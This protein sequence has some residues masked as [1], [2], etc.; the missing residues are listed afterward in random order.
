MIQDFMLYRYP[1][2]GL[3]LNIWATALS[4][5]KTYYFRIQ[6]R[7]VTLTGDTDKN[8]ILG[9]MSENSILELT[10]NIEIA[11]QKKWL[12]DTDWE[13]LIL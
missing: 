5:E 10:S 1:F 4:T 3:S 2:R 13:D 12:R 7:S 6:F 8:D 11:L 9:I